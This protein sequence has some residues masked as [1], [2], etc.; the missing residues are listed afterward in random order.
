MHRGLVSGATPC[1]QLGCASVQGTWAHGTPPTHAH[2][3]IPFSG[4]PPPGASLTLQLLPKHGQED[5]EVDGPR[6][7]LHHGLQLLVLYVDAA[8]GRGRV[9]IP[10][11]TV[12]VRG[13]LPAGSP[14]AQSSG[15][16]RLAESPSPTVSPIPPLSPKA[17]PTFWWGEPQDRG[18]FS[19]GLPPASPSPCHHLSLPGSESKLVV[20]PILQMR[21]L[22]PKEAVAHWS[23][24]PGSQGLMCCRRDPLAA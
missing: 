17:L 2:S 14:G 11:H 23:G 9:E 1:P 22:R 3:P 19:H 4:S 12:R 24:R 20:I 13:A 15:P 7:L 5:G 6:G 10:T 18:T 21:Q 16:Q 8:W